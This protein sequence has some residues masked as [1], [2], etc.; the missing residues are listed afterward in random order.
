MRS[1]YL[2]TALIV[3]TLALVI[4]LPSPAGEAPSKKKIDKLIEQLGSG[5]FAERE[6]ATKEL[7]AIGLPALDALRKAAQ[8]DDAEVRKRAEDL[9]PKIERQAESRRVLTPKRVRLVYKDTP[10]SEAVADFQKQSGYRI[11]LHDPQ[12]ELKERKITLDTKE[13]T[14]WHAFALFCDK[15]ELTEASMEDLIQAPQPPQGVKQVLPAPAPPG[16]APPAAAQ[17]AIMRPGR[18]VRPSMNGELVLKDGKAKKLP[19]NDRSAVRIRALRKSDLFGKAPEGE[20]ILPLEV[21]PEPKLQWQSLQSLHIE[22]AVDDQDQKLT[23]VVP[24]VEG[25]GGFGGGNVA[26][27]LPGGGAAMQQVQLWDVLHQLVPVQ[28]KKGA[29]AA[30]SLKELKGVLMAQLLT[31][32]QPMITVDKLDKA[33]GKVFKGELGGFIKIVEVKSQEQ[34]TTIR[35]E[36]EQPPYDKVVPA[37]PNAVPGAGVPIGGPRPGVK[38]LPAPAPAPAQVPPPARPVPPAGLAAQVPAAP[39]QPAPAAPPGAQIQIGGGGGIVVGGPMRLATPLNGLSVQDD[40]GNAVPI[41]IQQT[42]IR[43]GQRGNGARTQTI[44]YTLVCQH[45]KDQPAKVVYLGRKR[46]TVDIPFAL[47]D[48]PLP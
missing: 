32:A 21:S 35:L 18:I 12:G 28:L 13:T 4:S 45:D 36:F 2:L 7:A 42:Q 6:K 46:V 44:T 16:A 9:L 39:P 23:H 17:P 41:Q 31:E 47:K 20:I 22:K 19:T 34:Q 3:S 5:T 10:L 33:A 14:F 8:S 40:K 26:I 30:K 1:H 37:Q 15:A 38:I 43:I 24:Q 48:V 11:R 25:V 29:K 27:A